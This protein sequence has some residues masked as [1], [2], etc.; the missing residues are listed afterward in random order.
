MDRLAPFL[1]VGFFLAFLLSIAFWPGRNVFG[2][3]NRLDDHLPKYERLAEIAWD[4]GSDSPAVW[5]PSTPTL[6]EEARGLMRRLT[7]R[8]VRRLPFFCVQPLGRP[9]SCHVR[10]SAQPPLWTES[11]TCM[12]TPSRLGGHWYTSC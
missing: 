4:L 1:L 7:L 8:N 12:T 2:V 5:F 10:A 3:D 9:L 11:D 6:P